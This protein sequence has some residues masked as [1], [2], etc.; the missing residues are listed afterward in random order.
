MSNYLVQIPV[1]FSVE[2][3]IEANSREEAFQSVMDGEGNTTTDPLWIGFHPDTELEDCG[4]IA[5]DE[6]GDSE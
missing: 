5:L 4:I 1:I 6:E 2:F 3:E